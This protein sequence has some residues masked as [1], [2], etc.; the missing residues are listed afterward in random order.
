M[1]P[2]GVISNLSKLRELDLYGAMHADWEAAG[3]GNEERKASLE[4]LEELNSKVMLSTTLGITVN[5]VATLKILSRFDSIVTRRLFI[6]RMSSSASLQLTPSE[7]KAQLGSLK[8]LKSLQELMIAICQSL[9]EL[10]V[11]G[12]DGDR[13]M[14]WRLPA[15]ENLEL[16]EL[17]KLKVIKWR[18][19]S[20]SDFL[21]QL[22]ALKIIICYELENVNWVLQLPRLEILQIQFCPKMRRPID[23]PV[24]SHVGFTSASA[25]RCLKMLDLYSLSSLT[26]ICDQTIGFPSLEIIETVRCDELRELP[27][28]IMES[29]LREIRGSEGWWQ[30]LKWRN[31]NMKAS[32]LPSLKI[33]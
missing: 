21:P 9:V 17:M 25:F 33:R 24:G 10:E 27:L 30:S 20:I 29:K 19:V 12:G 18:R 23:E 13:E 11:D 31:E 5:A 6:K 1:I 4:E 28:K 32:L 15:L 16:C 7:V 22:R 8:I 3:G 2:R 14:D 26:S